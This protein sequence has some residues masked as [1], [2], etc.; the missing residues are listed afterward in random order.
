MICGVCHEEFEGD[1]HCW[2]DL[3][4]L[5]FNKNEWRMPGAQFEPSNHWTITDRHTMVMLEP[6]E[7]Q[8]DIMAATREIARGG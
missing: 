3:P 8:D 7:V 1:V 2:V 4:A 6:D 5:T